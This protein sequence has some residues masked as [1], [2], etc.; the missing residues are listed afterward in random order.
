MIFL[1]ICGEYFC[2]QLF[3][4][5]R[6]IN[7][8]EQTIRDLQASID[9]RMEV[10]ARHEALIQSLRQKLAEYES[11]YGNIEGA[12]NRSELT[13]VTLQQQNN[14]AQ[15]RIVELESRLR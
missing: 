11:A 2:V 13:I 10:D 7:A 4:A 6:E 3:E 15:Q 12:A 5:Q 1:W 14:E 8:R 9:V